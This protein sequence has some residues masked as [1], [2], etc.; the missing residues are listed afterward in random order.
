[1]IKLIVEPYCGKCREFDPVVDCSFYCDDDPL[2]LVDCRYSERCRSQMRY[3]KEEFGKESKDGQ[4]NQSQ[5]PSM[6]IG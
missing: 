2:M 1:M 4:E 6:R 3:L 5:M